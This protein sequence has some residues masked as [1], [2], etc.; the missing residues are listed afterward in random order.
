MD[1]VDMEKENKTPKKWDGHFYRKW[2][3]A[4]F[5]INLFYSATS[6]H[7][8]VQKNI[9]SFSGKILIFGNRIFN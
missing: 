6:A 1:F 8:A 9:L 4:N 2:G 3:Q 5:L 7:S